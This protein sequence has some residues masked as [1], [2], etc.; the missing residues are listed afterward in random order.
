MEAL[1]RMTGIT[2]YF[3]P[4][5]AVRNLDLELQPGEIV[6]LLGPNGAGK[7]TTM[8]ILSGCLG[9][10]EGRV[11]L[12]GVDLFQ[13]PQK[14]KRTIGYL[15]ETPPLYPELTV[16][17]YLGFCAR[18]RSLKRPELKAALARAK[19]LC[20][21]SETG[22]RL[23]R[24]LSKG[25]RQ[26]V[27]IAQAIIHSPNA[28]ILD[29]PT[30]GLD[31]NQI[32]EIRELIRML[33]KSHGIILSTHIL[34][35]VQSVCDRVLILHKGRLIYTEQL[36][37]L[38]YRESGLLTVRLNHPPDRAAIAGLEGV[39]NV[40]ILGNKRFGIQLKSK[41][42]IDALVNQIVQRNWGLL[43]LVPDKP[44]LEQVFYRL[45]TTEESGN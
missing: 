24:N 6:G 4:F 3:G 38:S 45:T 2:R 36:E 21:L 34:P 18:L 19:N 37:K 35:E 16:D 43:E 27:G 7:S 15:P 14:A 5:C 20:G 22:N 32:V 8:R 44:N 12:E 10:S 17:E 23:I 30:S 31:P 11:Q 41:G 13:H 33:G 26:R 9:A 39:L 1:I 42:S 29:E 40:T 25:Y 28:I